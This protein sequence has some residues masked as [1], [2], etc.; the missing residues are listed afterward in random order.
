MIPYLPICTASSVRQ[1]VCNVLKDRYTSVDQAE[2]AIGISYEGD[3]DKDDDNN[4]NSVNELLNKAKCLPL[5]D[6]SDLCEALYQELLAREKIPLPGRDFISHSVAAMQRL[7]QRQKSNVLYKLAKVIAVN[8]PDS[9]EPLMP[10]NR[11][12]WGLV[13]YQIDFFACSH[14]NEV[15]IVL[16]KVFRFFLNICHI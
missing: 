10:M 7:K 12:P 16:F 6:L 8:R 11:M 2:H 15:T 14:I 1:R 3:S 5:S 13:Q 9:T 4:G